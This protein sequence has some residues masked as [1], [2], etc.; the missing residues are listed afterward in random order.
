[1]NLS[2]LYESNSILKIDLFPEYKIDELEK[3]ILSH[4]F[5]KFKFY[6]VFPVLLADYLYD[7]L[8]NKDIKFIANYLKN[9]SFKINDTY[10]NDYQVIKGGIDLNYIKDLESTINKN[11][12]FIGEVLD[13][14]G[15]CGGYNLMWACASALYIANKI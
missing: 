5:L 1:M 9:W 11:I 15:L 3:L 7:I 12:Y 8:K 2:S 10:K 4:Q 14:N 6:N 13:I